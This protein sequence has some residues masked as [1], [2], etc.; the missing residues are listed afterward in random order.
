MSAEDILGLPPPPAD[1]RVAYG[2]D[3][4][5]FVD[6]RLPRAKEPHPAL[7]FIHGGFWRREV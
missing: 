1:Q 6:V 2:A 4:N 5:Q 3:P 7:L